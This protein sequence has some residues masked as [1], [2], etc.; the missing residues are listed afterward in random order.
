MPRPLSRHTSDNPPSP[1]PLGKKWNIT[2]LLFFR[3]RI[4]TYK[5]ICIYN[6]RRLNK[7]II[8]YGQ[9]RATTAI[10]HAY[11]WQYRQSDAH[12]AGQKWFTSIASLNTADSLTHAAHGW[13][14]RDQLDV[15]CFIISL[16]N[17]QHISDVNTS[18]LRSLRLICWV[19]YFM[20][21][22]GYAGWGTS[23]SACIRIPHHPSQTTT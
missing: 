4:Y 3:C 15:T 12:K 13:I 20:G 2:T 10:S 9:R 7:H 23:A 1:S 11:H 8:G 18:I 17:A 6:T 5:Y 22:Q 19:T 16:F 21:M 14:K